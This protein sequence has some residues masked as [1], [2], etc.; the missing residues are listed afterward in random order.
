MICGKAAGCSKGYTASTLNTRASSE[1]AA[2]VLHCRCDRIG[3]REEITKLCSNMDCLLPI[4]TPHDS[5]IGRGQASWDENIFGTCGRQAV[6]PE[7]PCFLAGT[8][9][10]RW[11]RG[12]LARRADRLERLHAPE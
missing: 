4:K 8:L 9:K 3:W 1:A 5:A 7:K 11:Q 2:A 10:L 6:S 12:R